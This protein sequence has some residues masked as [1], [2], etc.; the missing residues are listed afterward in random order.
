MIIDTH[1]HFIKPVDSRGNR[2]VYSP[3]PSSAEDYF[4]LMDA[5]GIDRAFFISWSPEDILS[6]LAVKGIAVETV[7]ETMSREY[8]LD[9]LARYPDRFY[10]FPCHL[11]PAIPDYLPMARENLALGAAGLKFAVSFWGELPDDERLIPLYDLARDHRAQVIIDTSYW[12]LGK[13]DPPTDPDTL[14][15]G[16]REVAKRVIDFADYARHLRAVFSAYPAI[17]FS[18]AHAGARNFN[19][20][21]AREAGSLMREYPNV[22]AD[23]GALDVSS[24]ALDALVEIAGSNRVMFGTDYPHFAQGPAMRRLID[25]IRRPGRFTPRVADMILGDNALAFVQEKKPG[26]LAAPQR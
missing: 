15:E 21:R 10:W 23:L 6:D 26:L 16:H 19:V 24:P 12:Y 17:N 2:Q 13:E 20:E 5:S 3:N 18:L 11:G 9:V 4:A 8:A 7:R 1:V 22:F 14:Q 25:H